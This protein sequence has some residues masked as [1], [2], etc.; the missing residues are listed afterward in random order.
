MGWWYA[1]ESYLD[2]MSHYTRGFPVCNGFTSNG[3]PRT[4]DPGDPG[5][6][7]VC[8]ANHLY[9]DASTCDLGEF[10]K[11]DAQGYQRVLRHSC[12]ASGGQSGS[13]IY[14]YVK[15]SPVVA[16]VHTFSTCG[17]TAMGT[18]CTSASDRP[19]GGTHI[20]KEYSD[21]I[22]FFREWAP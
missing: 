16:G 17:T 19:L 3:T 15:G 14:H 20:T 7:V 9:G 4:D 12:D 6:S 18:Q 13:P 11:S 8:V 21:A 5:S 22:A 2:T 10:S 1:G